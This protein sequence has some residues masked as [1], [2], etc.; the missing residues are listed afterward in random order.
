M[1]STSTMDPVRLFIE[2][3]N[4]DQ[5]FHALREVREKI[6][7]FDGTNISKYLNIYY[8]EMEMSGVNDV[9]MIANFYKLVDMELRDRIHEIQTLHSLD[10]N[11]FKEALVS[12]YAREDFSRVTMRSFHEWILKEDKGLSVADTK[13]EFDRLYGHL[14]PEERNS[15]SWQK[16]AL[17]LQ[18]VDKRYRKELELMLEV[19]NTED[20]ITADWNEVTNACNKFMKRMQRN[21]AMIQI[22]HVGITN[23]LEQN[24]E[25]QRLGREPSH[26]MVHQPREMTGIKSES[27]LDDLVQSMK[28]LTIKVAKLENGQTSRS[29]E[30]FR[31]RCM[32]CDSLE[33][34]LRDCDEYK[35]MENRDL[36]YWKNGKI[37]LTETRSPLTKNFGD[38]GVKVKFEEAEA[39]KASAMY[40]SATAGLR[41]DDKP[42]R[43]S[44]WEKV[45]SSAQKQKLKMEDLRVA[46]DSVR[47]N[48][49]W[50]VPVDA[51]TVYA[52]MAE[53]QE[54]EVIVEEKRKRPDDEIGSAKKH[55]TRESKRKEM[56][57]KV[58]KGK[59]GPSFKLM[60]DIEKDT[61][62]KKILETRI[63]DSR[64][65]FTLREVL[66]IAKKEF[67]DEIIDIVRRKKQ[68]NEQVKETNP[69][70]A[71]EVVSNESD[72]VI[73]D[74]QHAST[75]MI[76]STDVRS[77]YSRKCW[78][79]ATTEHHVKIGDV[80]DPVMALIDHGSEINIMSADF[81]RKGRWPID[82]QH[83]WRVKA[84]TSVTEDLFGAC[85][86]V[87]VTIG[88]IEVDQ[89][90]FVQEGSTYPII[91]GQPYITAVRMET[92]VLDNGSA[93]AKIRSQDGRRTVQFMTVRPNH[94]RNKQ[95]LRDHS[96]PKECDDF[97]NQVFD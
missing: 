70:V 11:A 14:K 76:S 86:N 71:Y 27:L 97:N 5:L 41:L 60:S 22:P 54:H 1:A 53:H 68:V 62:L 74:S 59:S 66:G 6:G 13:K 38:G 75:S 10:W 28:D 17:F 43:S 63:L 36:V 33:H 3:L 46:G 50:D 30:P 34:R 82:T 93:Y 65:E 88:D 80:P 89:H 18:A 31:P 55:E 85:P 83:G 69:K 16:V 96:I 21:V 52:Q 2:K 73:V 7:V 12:E 92:K 24:I 57:A 49:G 84:A 39:K 61:D 48:T 4:Q 40:Y 37:Y 44:F 56:D 67:H 47:K 23:R 35:D 72:N 19:P 9:N 58:E 78:A 51:M 64:V 32:W 94:E 8:D 77:H 26:E 29:R 15:L 90:F 87:K 79:R 95:E 45:V 91:L 81:Y 25:V 20:G 42:C